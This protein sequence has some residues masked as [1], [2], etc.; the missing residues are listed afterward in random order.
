MANY[1]L[2]DFGSTFTKLTAVST[3]TQDIIGTASH[4]TTVQT[5]IAIG[6]HYALDKLT[7]SIGQ[8]LVFDE[9]IA[10]S[11]AAGGLKMAAIGLIEELTVEAAKR[12]CLGAGAKVDLVF[13]HHLT[14]HEV[15]MIIDMKIDIILL[16]GGADGG[17]SECV[18]FNARLLGEMGVKA[19]VLFA[20]N[21]SCQ[22]EILAIFDEYGMDGHIAEN[23][24]PKINQ[25]NVK[26]A[27]D[28]IRDLF[29][30]KII[31][32]KGIKQIESEIDKVILP[33]PQAV[34]QAAELLAKGYMNEPGIGELVMV[35]IG[36]ATTDMYS[37][38]NP[39]RRSDVILQGLEEPF[40]KR[41]VEG[42]LGMRYSALGVL[43]S[44]TK[45]EILMI[46]A[47]KNIDIEK[48]VRFRASHIDAIPENNYEHHVDQ[49]LAEMCAYKAMSRHAGKMEEVYTPMGM[50]YNQIGKD[51]TEVEYVIGTGG[52]IIKSRHPLDIL[53]KVTNLF[54]NRMELRPTRPAYLLDQDYIMSAMGLL[55][56]NQPMLALKIMKKRLVHL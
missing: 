25:L 47:E 13:A 35:D 53:M 39:T 12:V 37:M 15:K 30:E 49:I 4:F 33:T 24:M 3:E 16:A 31:E 27:R 36:G 21:K 46:N 40:A 42:D 22:D 2:I 20:G 26:A 41:T 6:Y 43:K 19:P 1:L 28:K 9:I 23:V 51:L 34:L 18:L 56:Q 14:K 52:A 32:A 8:K 29:L 54:R 50:C 17:N 45:D 7:E 10:C 48:D 55:S 5:D 44:L 38:S 11:S